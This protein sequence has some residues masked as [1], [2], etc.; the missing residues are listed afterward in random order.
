MAGDILSCSFLWRRPF[1]AFG[2]PAERVTICSLDQKAEGKNSKNL[3]VQHDKCTGHDPRSL[4]FARQYNT[5]THL[6][7]WSLFFLACQWLWRGVP[8]RA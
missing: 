6:L 3:H 8:C 1:A 5:K 2:S 7:V 4:A